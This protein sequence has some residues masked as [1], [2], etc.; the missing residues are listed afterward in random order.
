MKQK[1]NESIFNELM[2]ETE[3]RNIKR[4]TLNGK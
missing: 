2:N 3:S 4:K 1:E